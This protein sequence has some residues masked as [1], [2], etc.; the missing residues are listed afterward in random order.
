[1][2]WCGDFAIIS[3][4]IGHQCDLGEEWG[5]ERGVVFKLDL[6]GVVNI[7]GTGIIIISTIKNPTLCALKFQ[8]VS[9][10]VT[11]GIQN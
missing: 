6:F 4:D 5:G 2:T 8:L 1:M 3:V 10:A 9:K 11:G 7:T